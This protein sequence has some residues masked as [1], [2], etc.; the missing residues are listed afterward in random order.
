[1]NSRNWFVV[2]GGSISLWILALG[3]QWFPSAK[4]SGFFYL[5]GESYYYDEEL[6]QVEDPIFSGFHTLAI[7]LTVVFWSLAVYA[8]IRAVRS[9]K[10]PG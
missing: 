5:V 4:L 9:E 10:K 6:G 1:M 8:L 3:I 2:C 7:S